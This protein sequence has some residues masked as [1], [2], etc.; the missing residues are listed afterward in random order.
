MRDEIT[1]SAMKIHL[2]CEEIEK[3]RPTPDLIAALL[4]TMDDFL[5]K[6]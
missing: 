6:A 5:E 1:E 4:R 2:I 3:R